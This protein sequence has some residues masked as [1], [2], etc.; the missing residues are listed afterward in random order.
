MLCIVLIAVV[1]ICLFLCLGE[2]LSFEKMRQ[3]IE[4]VDKLKDIDC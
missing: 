3:I 4:Q 1:I 2:P